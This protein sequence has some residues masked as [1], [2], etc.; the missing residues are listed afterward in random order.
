MRWLRYIAAAAFVF[1]APKVFPA[2]VV[3]SLDGSGDFLSIQ[4]ALDSGSEEIVVLPG[5]YEEALLVTGPVVLRAAAGPLVT[6]IHAP[7]D[8]DAVTIDGVAGVRVTG[9]A[10]TGG[11]DGVRIRSAPDIVISN[12]VIHDNARHGVFASWRTGDAMPEVRVLNNVIL[13]Q[14][15]GDAVLLGGH[16]RGTGNDKGRAEMFPAVVANNVLMG[17]RGY[18][19]RVVSIDGTDQRDV[20]EIQ[21]AARLIIRSNNN[22]DNRRGQYGPRIGPAPSGLVDVVTGPGEIGLVPGFLGQAGGCGPDVRLLTTS[23]LVDSGDTASPAR[24]LD[25]SVLDI[26]AFGGPFA[27]P[28]FE[29][30]VNGPVVSSVTAE[31]NPATGEITVNAAASVRAEE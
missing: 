21:Q 31:I 25:G 2:E 8:R 28:F 23:N 29:S 15:G 12:N 14:F 7:Q 5:T 27:A 26:G 17:N 10:I 16:E 6:C 9:F 22:V 30:A 20:V 4:A 3:V 11:V 18:G 19:V 13:D 24:D 1:A